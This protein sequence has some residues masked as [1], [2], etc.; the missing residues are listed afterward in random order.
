MCKSSFAA[1]SA[2]HTG[3]QSS[4]A[5][6]AEADKVSVERNHQ[7]CCASTLTR[8]VSV[9]QQGSA[10]SVLLAPNKVYRFM[11]STCRDGA[12]SQTL[13]RPTL[14]GSLAVL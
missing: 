14:F 8:G 1:A 11:H 2:G 7:T 12:I 13:P 6:V 3:Q 5:A 10:L 4:R 9:D